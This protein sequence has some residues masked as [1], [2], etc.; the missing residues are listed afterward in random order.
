MLLQAVFPKRADGTVG[1]PVGLAEQGDARFHGFAEPEGRRRMEVE[2]AVA[3]AGMG[4]GWPREEEG[5]K[6]DEL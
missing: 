3:A 6:K 5:E 4:R 2:V 1:R